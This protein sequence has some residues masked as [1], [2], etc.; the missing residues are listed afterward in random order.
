MNEKNKR[1]KLYIQTFTTMSFADAFNQT[2]LIDYS[3][4]MTTKPFLGDMLFPNRK[5]VD[6][7]ASFTEL[8]AMIP[9]VASV[10]GFDTS[11]EIG[12]RD[13][14]NVLEIEKML[15]KRKLPIN[16]ELLIKLSNPRNQQEFSELIERLYNDARI[17]SEGVL[18]RCE[19]MKMEVLANG[20]LSF[21]ENNVKL[22]LDYQVPSGH[23]ET[24]TGTSLWSDTANSK[25]LEDI[26]EW[27]DKIVDDQ[28]VAPER[29]LT[30]NK[31][32]RLLCKNASI[33]LAVYGQNQAGKLV[34]LTELNNLF[35]TMG[36]PLIE[37]YDEKYRKQ[38]ANGKY[39]QIRY[40]PED[41]FVMFPIDNLGNGCF[42]YTPEE[43]NLAKTYDVTGMGNVTLTTYDTSDPVAQWTKATG[44]FVP[45]FPAYKEV[46][47]SKVI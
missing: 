20:S 28:G 30:S 19:A 26:Q 9:I 14:F 2:E 22:T 3:R 4:T 47:Q 29:A 42:G 46:F 41:K 12:S 31:V 21:D 11:A 24:L 44:L 45:T 1:L 23:K 37:T 17:L 43:R 18:A 39:T 32:V 8:G 10:H 5:S 13:G 25:P 35:E 27:Y 36:L 38:S 34:T 40:F 6:L 16:E 33:Q 7:K 15:I